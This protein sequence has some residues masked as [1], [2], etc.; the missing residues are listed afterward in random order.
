ML[1]MKLWVQ[2]IFLVIGLQFL[3]PM[4]VFGEAVST[5]WLRVTSEGEKIIRFHFFWSKACPHC[6]RAKPFVS[7]LARSYDWLELN[8]YEISE[9]PESAA[10]YK[11][12]S[13][14][15]GDGEFAVPAFLFCEQAVIG[16]L[17]EKTT[18]AHLRDELL[19]CR[20]VL[21]DGRKEISGQQVKTKNISLPIFGELDPDSI[22]L[23]VFT[24]IIAGLDAFNPCAF[25]VL[26]LMLSLLVNAKDRKRMLLIGG[27]FVFCSGFIYFI[28]MAAWLNLFLYIGEIRTIT[29]IAAIVA[30]GISSI[31]I[32]DYFFFQKGV[33]LS[34]PDS[35]K[36]GLYE[37]IR[38]LMGAP[39]LP[40]MIMGTVM[41]A[42]VANSY[43]LLCTA[44]FPMVFTRLLTLHDLTSW[45][46]YLY[47]VFYNIIY[48]IPLIAIVLI[49]A[50]TLGSRK[51]SEKEGR[52]LKL[53]SG[54]M[55]LELGL[56][57]L[58]APELLNHLLTAISLIAVAILL[59]FGIAH[60]DRKIQG[61][62]MH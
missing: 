10:L 40:T 47:L 8:S 35:A 28:F 34:I 1:K 33:S 24:I 20:A 36:P 39:S 3:L 15:I 54:V 62:E 52:I 53:V 12:L 19:N 60:F 46:Y 38:G 61:P 9:N 23:P 17:D 45:G 21:V 32:K 6:R 4:F 58:F 11:T 43:E 2:T 50:K 5:P 30:I 14:K 37:R 25:F 44:G 56:L 48:V 29:V 26:L 16:Y 49:F 57:L 13:E 42:I 7:K 27:I 51:L 55:M 22:S 59:T 31:N 18:G 41:L